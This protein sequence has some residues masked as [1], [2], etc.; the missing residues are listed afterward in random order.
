MLEKLNN[1]NFTNISNNP[2]LGIEVGREDPKCKLD[3]KPVF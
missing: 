3:Q 2:N 1:I